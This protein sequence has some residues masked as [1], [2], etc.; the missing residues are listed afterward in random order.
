MT[1]PAGECQEIFMAAVSAPNTGKAVVRVT[2]V[3]VPVMGRDARRLMVGAIL[4]DHL[5]RN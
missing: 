2:T 4:S 3:Q 5:R 1:A